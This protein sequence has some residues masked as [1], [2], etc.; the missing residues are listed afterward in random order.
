VDIQ[1]YIRSCQP[2]DSFYVNILFYFK[3]FYNFREISGIDVKSFMDP[4][5]LQMGYPLLT[6]NRIN[7]THIE[8]EQQRFSLD[9]PKAGI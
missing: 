1:F 7:K 4:W 5:L 3:H 9:D 2:V 6:I 8:V